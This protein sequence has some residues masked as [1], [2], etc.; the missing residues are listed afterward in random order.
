MKHREGTTTKIMGKAS[1][2]EDRGKTA[3]AHPLGEQVQTFASK[4][5]RWNGKSTVPPPLYPIPSGGARNKRDAATEEIVPTLKRTRFLDN[6]EGKICDNDEERSNN[7]APGGNEKKVDVTSA[8]K[9]MEPD[10]SGP[11]SSCESLHND[12]TTYASA[13]VSHASRV[14]KDRLPLGG[15][16]F[17]QDI[18][19]LTETDEADG[20]RPPQ[21]S[22]T[23]APVT[24]CDK[25]K[26]RKQNTIRRQNRQKHQTRRSQWTHYKGDF[27]VPDDLPPAQQHRNQMCPS[28]LARLHPAGDLLSEWSQLGCPTMTGRPWTVIEMEA[29]I[30]RGPHKSALTPEAMAHFAAEIT[31]KVAAGQAKIVVWDDIRNDPPPQLKISPIAAVPHTSK[32]FRSILDLS[33]ALKLSNGETIPAVNDSTTKT[34]PSAS[35]DQLGHSLVRLIHAFA[36][37]GPTDKIFMAKWD[38]KDGFWRLDCA[39]GEE[40]NFAYVLPQPEGMPV[41]LVIPTS[42]Q[43]GWIESPAYFC[44]ASETSR[45]V[46][47]TYAQAPM[48]SLGKHKFEHFMVGS[49]AFESLPTSVPD[50]ENFRFLVEVFVD[51]FMSLAIATSKQQ[52]LHVGTGTMMGI[53]D[54]FPKCEIKNQDPISEKKMERGDSSFDTQKTLLGFDFDGVEKSMWLEED[55]R[56]SLLL[57]LK[58][59]LRTCSRTNHGIP[60][61]SFESVIAKLRHAFTA[62]PAGLGLLSPCNSVLALK[63]PI[64]FLQR[65]RHL[66]TAI[67]GIRTLLRESIATPTK[68]RELVDGW[69]H[70]IGYTDASNMGFGGIVF[71]EDSEIPPTVFRGQWPDDV[72]K[73]IVSVGN[74]NGRLSINDLEMAGLLFTFLV[75][76][77]VCPSLHE[78][79]VAMFSD[80]QPSVSWVDRMASRK[81][82]AGAHLLRALALRLKLH[83]CCPLTPLHTAGKQNSMADVA[84]RSFGTPQ[85]WH[86][87]SDS[88]FANLFNTLFPLPHQNTW[89]VFHLTNEIC[90]RVISILRTLDST[91]DEWRRIPKIGQAIGETGVPTSNLWEWTRSY[92]IL[93]TRNEI[94]CS[95]DLPQ[96]V[97]RATMERD[98]K[99][100]LQQYLQLSQ[101]LARRSP[102]SSK[103]IH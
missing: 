95:Q 20:L 2:D 89:T 50:N 61:K 11:Y 93:T 47:A 12:I 57:I 86:C 25:K 33:F 80:N 48:G 82:E 28:G 60:F 39:D 35:V 84:S 42:L 30:E 91:L 3:P 68:C 29:A 16:D 21:L 5:E 37:A 74:R 90:M 59:W 100:K 65:N 70:Y 78:K 94:E 55:K 19:M 9:V 79:H 27:F 81:S 36:E 22:D 69:P 26:L 63:P 31:E 8:D 13:S 72:R 18:S 71:G 102:W 76:E 96:D 7:S 53:H 54:V 103:E 45:D 62:I 64:V 67:Q 58:G 97:E 88:E 83:R 34:A 1:G 15:G 66:L 98:N 52:L 43:M 87:T 56:S 73:E 99:S 24:G 40:Y 46:A 4:V 92:N 101:P 17:P 49:T 85:Q 6:G 14:P 75:M 38:V 44:S 77:A 41:T 10:S 32:P 51:D 23:N